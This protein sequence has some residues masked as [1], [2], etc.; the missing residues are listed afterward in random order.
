LVKLERFPEARALGDS[1]SPFGRARP[2]RRRVLAGV[3]VLTGQ[4]NRAAALLAMDV[5]TPFATPE[6]PTSCSRRAS[7]RPLAPCSC[8][9][10]WVHRPKV[11]PPSSGR[12]TR[13][14]ASWSSR[15]ARPPLGARRSATRRCSHSPNRPREAHAGRSAKLCS[16]CSSLRRNRAVRTG[17]ARLDSSRGT[18]RS[19]DIA[20]ENV[21]QEAWLLVAGATRRRRSSGSIAR[22]ARSALG[23]ALLA[24]CRRRR[25]VR[26]MRWRAELARRPVTRLPPPVGRGR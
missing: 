10:R 14:V 18:L 16:S 24:K 8:T 7:R 1:L 19:G 11:S 6:G 12:V 22:S 23:T 25:L 20:I 21:Y 2:R 26:A 9:P 5:S 3:A 15:S 4:V 13:L 17:I